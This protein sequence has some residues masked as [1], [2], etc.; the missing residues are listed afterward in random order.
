MIGQDSFR[1]EQE[2]THILTQNE[3][4]FSHLKNQYQT[5]SKNIKIISLS[6]VEELE[7]FV[8]AN[9]KLILQDVWL[10]NGFGRF[11][12]DKFFQDYGGISL[13]DSFPVFKEKGSF[14]I[15]NPFNTG[16]YLDR[17]VYSAFESGVSALSMKTFFDH[18]VMY[19]AG[20][21]TK[22][23]VGLPLEVTYGNFEDIFGIQIHFFSQDLILED[24]TLS[25]SKHVSKRAE[26]YLLNVSVDSS[27]FF[28]FTFLQEVNKAVITALWSKD[29]RIKVENRGLLISELSTNA[30][31][32]QYPSEGLSSFQVQKTQIEDLSERVVL[33]AKSQ[34][35]DSFSTRLKPSM[36]EDDVKQMIPGGSQGLSEEVTLVKGAA[37]TEDEWTQI[38][39]GTTDF[40]TDEFQRINGLKDLESND[41]NLIKGDKNLDQMDQKQLIKGSKES[42]TESRTMIKGSKDTLNQNMM[43]KSFASDPKVKELLQ[44]KSFTDPMPKELK[45]SFHEHLA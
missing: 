44:V 37:D 1:P 12:L 6:P 26:E 29:E 17:M 34:N 41:I 11:I 24:L 18:I 38:L 5:L 45:Q 32:A 13:S 22:G 33:P 35:T 30:P 31:I 7:D 19:L 9:G 14:N 43:T 2:L 4:D 21:K 8:G 40:K 28:D 15:A 25:L 16:E 36:T 42:T 10:K 39:S 23:K 3:R 27:D 20:L